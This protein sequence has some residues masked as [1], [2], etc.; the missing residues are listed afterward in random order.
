MSKKSSAAVDGN[1]SAGQYS[2][3]AL[4]ALWEKL[5]GQEISLERNMYKIEECAPYPVAGFVVD[6]I[7]MPA[8]DRADNPDWQAAV[9]ELTHPTK[10]V[11]RKGEV[12]IAKPGEEI[13]MPVSWQLGGFLQRFGLDPISLHEVAI[14]PGEKKDM[15]NLGGGKKMHTFVVKDLQ[16]KKQRTFQHKFDTMS[17][18]RQLPGSDVA[19]A[20]PSGEQVTND[21]E[22]IPA[23]SAAS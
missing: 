16:R 2:D 3:E 17:L 22:M 7:Q 8:A 6:V 23:A 10:V 13:W 18:A 5:G 1:L 12:V 14:K 15:V 9:I 19:G 20:L 11:N 4:L 21:G